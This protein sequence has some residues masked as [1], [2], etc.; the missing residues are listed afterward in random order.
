MSTPP[1]GPATS[2]P[3]EPPRSPEPPGALTIDSREPVRFLG[4]EFEYKWVVTAVLVSALFLDILDTTIVNVAL[5]TLVS[6]F[7]ESA[8]EWTVIGYTLSLAVFIPVS[9]WLSDRM[10]NKRIFMFAFGMF[11]VA[12]A[13]CALSQSVGQLIAFRVL[14]G[15]GGG[16]L[17]PVGMAMLFR[18]FPPAERARVAVVMMVPA[19]AAPALG[20]I[21]GGVLVTHLS[22]R[23]IFTINIPIGLL[24]LAIGGTL[25][26][27]HREPTAGNFDLPGFLLSAIGFAGFV[28]GV[29]DGPRSGWTSPVVLITGLGG[30][31]VIALMVVVELRRSTPMLQLRLLQDR[32]FRQTN[33]VSVMTTGS[34]MGIMFVIPLYLQSLRGMSAQESGLTTFPQAIGVAVA[35]VIAGRVYLR[36]GPRRLIAAGLAGAAIA[37][38]AFAFITLGTSLWVIRGLMFARGFCMGFAFVPMQAASYATIAPADNGRA[39]SIFSTQ[40][41]V[42]VSVAV[43]VF[44]TVL[45]TYVSYGAHGVIVNP[46]RALTGFHVTFMIAAGMAIVGSLVALMIKDSDAAGTMA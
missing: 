45:A 19:M 3:S 40:R 37:I 20:P 41:Q 30:L 11:I 15:V 29:S 13:L 28:Y 23:W 34:F 4:R 14:Q 9:G 26:H 42:A 18:V 1:A 43:A 33:L 6:E 24:A 2:A 46:D 8:T 35:S 10:G 25:L 44:A 36:I 21:I 17:T 22:W 38:G 27:E 39:A 32:L 7:G 16:M 5:P 31:A 12:S